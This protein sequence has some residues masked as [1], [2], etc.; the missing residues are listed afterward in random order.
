MYAPFSRGYILL[1]PK[2]WQEAGRQAAGARPSS[3]AAL[4]AALGAAIATAA[5]RAVRMYEKCILEYERRLVGGFGGEIVCFLTLVL[6][7]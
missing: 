5:E 6:S 4:G 2:D 3:G 1:T 7:Y